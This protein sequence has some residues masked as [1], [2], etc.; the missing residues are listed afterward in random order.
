MA[1]DPSEYEKARPALSAFAQKMERAVRRTRAS[2]TGQ[3]HATVRQA[4]ALALEEEGAHPM[5]PQVVDELARQI[6]EGA[7]G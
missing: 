6:S 3:P 5:V 4:L 1:V 2:Y 7:E